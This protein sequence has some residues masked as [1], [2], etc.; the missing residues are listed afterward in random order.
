MMNVM[1]NSPWND[2][3]QPN[4]LVFPASGVVQDRAFE[5]DDA[6]SEKPL[7]ETRQRRLLMLLRLSNCKGTRVSMEV[8]NQLVSWVITYLRDLLPTYIRNLIH[9]LSTMD[10][11]VGE[12]WGNPSPKQV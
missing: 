12:D 3:L 8:S 7:G 5:Q 10:F 9:L 2:M 4:Q 1:V 6:A 11:P